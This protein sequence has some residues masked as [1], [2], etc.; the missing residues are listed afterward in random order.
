MGQILISFDLI[1]FPR[2]K[3]A[4]GHRTMPPAVNVCL[5]FEKPS[6]CREVSLGRRFGVFPG[7]A[8]E[9]HSGALVVQA[10]SG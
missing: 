6:K 8:L 10:V 9:V 2:P 5:L 4:S 3:G 7:S 1:R